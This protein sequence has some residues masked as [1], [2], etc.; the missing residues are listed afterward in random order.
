[1]GVPGA[2]GAQEA[3]ARQFLENLQEEELLPKLH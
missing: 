1:M 2:L 3:I